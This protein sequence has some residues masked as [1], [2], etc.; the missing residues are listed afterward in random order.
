MLAA[1]SAAPVLAALLC[2]PTCAAAQKADCRRPPALAFRKGASG[3]SVSGGV[4]RAESAC[5]A[6]EAGMG[7]TLEIEVTSPDRNVVVSVYRPG[8]RVRAA[9]DGPD[10]VGATLRGASDEDEATRI[11]SRL[12]ASGR[13]LLVLGTTRGAG[14]EFHMRVD[15]R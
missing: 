4:A 11:V 12:P 1:R 7:Q 2:W 3:A 9:S 5:Y 10:F 15:V 8:Y 14:G 6:V 13:Y